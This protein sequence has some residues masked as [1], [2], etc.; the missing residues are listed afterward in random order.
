MSNETNLRNSRG[1]DEQNTTEERTDAPETTE[2]ETAQPEEEEQSRKKKK[3]K[4]IHPFWKPTRILPIWL[5][6][7]LILAAAAAAAIAGAMIGYSII[8]GGGNPG[9]VLNPDLWYHIYDIIFEGT[10][11]DRG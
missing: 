7:V 4:G 6:L 8:G 5:R 9:D 11:R 3:R 2:E 1:E 10:D